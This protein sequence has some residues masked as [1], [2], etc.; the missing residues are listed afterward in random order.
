MKRFTKER[1]FLTILSI[2]FQNSNFR[3]PFREKN[4]LAWVVKYEKSNFRKS[5]G[6][7]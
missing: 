3:F 5:L 4:S 6:I 2:T 1:I 7:Y